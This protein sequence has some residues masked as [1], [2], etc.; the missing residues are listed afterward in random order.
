MVIPFQP[1]TSGG[2]SPDATMRSDVTT[3]HPALGP[4]PTVVSPGAI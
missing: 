2:S 3:K 1:P 4:A